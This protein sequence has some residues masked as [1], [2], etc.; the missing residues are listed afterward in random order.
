MHTSHQS[1]FHLKKVTLNENIKAEEE[2]KTISVIS[3]ISMN[4]KLL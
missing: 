2:E 4:I 3:S 1:R